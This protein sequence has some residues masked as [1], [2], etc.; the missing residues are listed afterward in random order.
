MKETNCPFLEITTVCYCKAFPVK[1]MIPAEKVTSAKGLC[2]TLHYQE[3]S[4][5]REISCSDRELTS[6]RGILLRSD[7]YYHPRHLWVHPFSVDENDVKVGIDDFAQ[8]VIGDIERISFPPEGTAVKENSVC[9]LVSSAKGAVKTTAPV[10]GIIKE[11]NQRL[12]SDP[13]LVNDDPYLEG[14]VFTIGLMGD[15]IKGLFYGSCAKN[16]INWEVERLQRIVA[17]DLGVTATNGGEAIADISGQLNK[18]QWAK[19]VSQF[20]G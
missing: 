18:A 6:V 8:K 10:N 14:W 13:S 12:L 9:F 4:L 3:C 16:W 20:V 15:G 17:A 1:K 19:I 2:S 7:Y 5:F 11:V